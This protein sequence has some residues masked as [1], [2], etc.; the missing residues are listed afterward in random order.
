MLVFTV[1][2]VFLCSYSMAQFLRHFPSP[3]SLFCSFVLVM[4]HQ[5]FILQTDTWRPGVSNRVILCLECN[6]WLAQECISIT[7]CGF[8]MCQNWLQ[9]LAKIFLS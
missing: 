3:W 2:D 1:A 9:I 8:L 5:L 6:H 4:K 7:P